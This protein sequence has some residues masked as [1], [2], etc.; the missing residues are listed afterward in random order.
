MSDE[1]R[2]VGPDAWRAAIEGARAHGWDHFDWLSAVDEIGREPSLRV[3]CRL[4]AADGGGLRVDTLIPREA[5]ALDSVASVFAGAAWHERETAESFGIEFRGGDPRPL[6]LAASFEGPPLRKDEVSGARAGRPWP[7][8]KEPGGATGGGAR[9]LVPAGVPD[10]DVWG[11]R[12]GEAA[13]PDEV[14]AS[15]DGA[16]VRRR[17]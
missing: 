3:I 1:L 6:L 8:A 15:V 14:A 7:G 17:R 4:R 10:P 12:R 11:D 16:R 5:A 13:D 2:R 9:R